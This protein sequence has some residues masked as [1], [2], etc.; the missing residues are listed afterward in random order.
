M[1]PLVSLFFHSLAFLLSS[2]GFNR[3]GK[4]ILLSS[5]FVMFGLAWFAGAGPMNISG[6]Y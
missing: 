4:P 2:W 3:S 6:F 1:A 5:S